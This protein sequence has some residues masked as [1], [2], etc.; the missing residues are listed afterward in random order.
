M[1]ARVR[2]TG[3]V[4]KYSKN[5]EN[6]EPMHVI[7]A[8]FVIFVIYCGGPLSPSLEKDLLLLR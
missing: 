8:I 4:H 5:N 7:F 1:L 6:N 2:A 3:A